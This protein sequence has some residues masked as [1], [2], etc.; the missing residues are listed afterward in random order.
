M[1]RRGKA[2]EIVLFS[3]ICCVQMCRNCPIFHILSNICAFIRRVKL[4]SSFC[5]FFLVGHTLSKNVCRIPHERDTCCFHWTWT[6]KYY[7]CICVMDFL[8]VGK[9]QFVSSFFLDSNFFPINIH[10]L[11]V[12]FSW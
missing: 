12:F 2:R 11:D 4:R 9:K 8:L 1:Y 6:F 3:R 5:F 7:Q 10:L